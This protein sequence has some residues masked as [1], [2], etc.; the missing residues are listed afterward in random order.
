MI[1]DYFWDKQFTI[2]LNGDHVRENGQNNQKQNLKLAF[3]FHIS[4]TSFTQPRT[5][6]KEMITLSLVVSSQKA[7]IVTLQDFWE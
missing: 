5:D 4:Q 1:S 3:C 7:S 6:V 2:S